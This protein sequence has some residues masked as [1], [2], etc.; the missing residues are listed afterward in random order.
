MDRGSFAQQPSVMK[1]MM[2]I[3]MIKERGKL[4]PEMCANGK[5]V[6]FSVC[7]R[8]LQASVKHHS[9]SANTDAHLLPI[10][11]QAHLSVRIAHCVR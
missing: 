9:T 6:A 8:I 10:I 11:L 7:L 5:A 1:L 3:I 4:N 2:S